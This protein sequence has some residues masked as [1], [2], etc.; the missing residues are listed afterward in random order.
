MPMQH[1][2]PGGDLHAI[3]KQDPAG[4]RVQRGAVDEEEGTREPP[5]RDL[6]LLL[7]CNLQPIAEP[8]CAS[9]SS[10]ITGIMIRPTTND[11]VPTSQA[12]PCSDALLH[13]AT[14]RAMGTASPSAVPELCRAAE[15]PTRHSQPPSGPKPQCMDEEL[16]AHECLHP[17]L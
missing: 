5:D 7:L 13:T 17:A 6:A 4:P 2:L 12:K 16:P 1:P 9:I 3:D 15:S 11:K 10:S 14:S 8:L